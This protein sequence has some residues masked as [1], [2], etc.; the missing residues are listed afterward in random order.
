M[1]DGQ[2]GLAGLHV[3]LIAN[4]IRDEVVATLRQVMEENIV[5]V[6]TPALLTVLEECA[7][8]SLTQ[9]GDRYGKFAKTKNLASQGKDKEFDWSV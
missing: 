6:K 7:Q 4:T 9:N 1:G 8:V 5:W 3:D 2:H